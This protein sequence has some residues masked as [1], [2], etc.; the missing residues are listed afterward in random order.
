ML[1]CQRRAQTRQVN[2]CPSSTDGRQRPVNAVS[3]NVK[4][5]TQQLV[6]DG[7]NSCC[8]LIIRL[9]SQSALAMSE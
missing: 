8:F 9:G 3:H 7:V 4:V 5:E 2:R 6:G 1:P